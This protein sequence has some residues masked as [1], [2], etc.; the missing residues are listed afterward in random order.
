MTGRR[1]GLARRR[2]AMGFTQESLAEHL[3]LERT[4][5]GRWERGSGTPQPWT[6]PNLAKALNLSLDAL[7]KLLC[8]PAVAG[9]DSDRVGHAMRVPD[10]MD[11]MTVAEL[12]QRVQILAERYDVEPSTALLADAGHALGQI[13]FFT[14][15][16]RERTRIELRQVEAEA[17]T[18]MG[19]LVWDASQ[20][21]DHTN[22]RRYL[23]QAIIAAREI[24]DVAAEGHALLR[25]SYIS[26]YGE[27]DPRAGLALTQE[28]ANTTEK[29][30]RVLTGLALLHTAEA[31]AML[32][33][34]RECERALVKAESHLVQATEND[35][36]GFLVSATQ[37]DRLAGSCYL[38]LGDHRRAQSILEKSARGIGRQS[39]SR[40]IVLGNLS[41]SY[42]RQGQLDSATAVL[43]EAIDVVEATRGGG[44]LN[45]IFDAGR[46][47][48]QWR[49]EKSVQ[50]VYD[51]LLSLMTAA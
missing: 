18:L 31:N 38:F 50:D 36:A 9:S 29:T 23:E 41:T 32:G 45:V 49:G 48:R 6:Q 28:T 4:A 17:A 16:A 26:L 44:G 14:G 3:G 21:R 10:R 51:R 43:H 7:D 30:S 12:R 24:G 40:A 39:K 8:E 11:L 46:E 19:Q 2:A 5:V 27:R 15:H 13:A 37:F 1:H 22:A 25:T 34:S 42:L 20:R 35:R 47:L 33:D